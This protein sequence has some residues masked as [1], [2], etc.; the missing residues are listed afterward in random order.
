MPPR[1]DAEDTCT[2]EGLPPLLMALPPL[3]LIEPFILITTGLSTVREDPPLRPILLKQYVP[4]RIVTD[5]PPMTERSPR[6]RS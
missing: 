5:L 2:A 6:S 1:D 3:K 4:P